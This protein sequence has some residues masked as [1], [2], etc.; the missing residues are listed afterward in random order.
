MN[1]MARNLI[2]AADGFLRGYGF[3]IQDGSSLFTEQFRETL[4]SAGVEPLKLPAR[5][6]NC[7]R[8]SERL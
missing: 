1:Q 4:R 3:L 5:S 6:P 2:D 8:H 7:K